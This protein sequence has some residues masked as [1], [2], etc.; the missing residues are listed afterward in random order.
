MASSPVLA[1]LQHT[2]R[3]RQ[4]RITRMK[5]SSTITVMTTLPPAAPAL[6]REDVRVVYVPDQL[7][8]AA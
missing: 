8:D 5:A 4:N 3:P 2:K 1:G 7:R 6:G